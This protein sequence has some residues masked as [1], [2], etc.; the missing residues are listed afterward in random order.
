MKS[1]LDSLYEAREIITTEIIKVK[2]IQNSCEHV[3]TPLVY[4]PYFEDDK[5]HDRWCRRC[6]ICD[7]VEYTRSFEDPEFENE[8]S[9]T[10]TR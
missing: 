7:K 3:F 6:V 5:S 1:R 8:F 4:D 2:R 10:R 9:Y